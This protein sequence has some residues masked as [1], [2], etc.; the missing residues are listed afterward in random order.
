[1]RDEEFEGMRVVA[2]FHLLVTFPFGL[3][4]V[5]EN[6]VAVVVRRL[7][8][9]DPEI[10]AGDFSVGQLLVLFD[11]LCISPSSA[12]VEES[13]WGFHVAF[14]FEGSSGRGL[15]DAFSPGRA[16]AA[17]SGFVRASDFDP[18]TALFFVKE[19]A[20]VGALPGVGNG[21]DGLLASGWNCKKRRCEEKGEEKEKFH[22][23]KLKQI[24]DLESQKVFEL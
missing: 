12:Y 6:E 14:A 10:A 21:D 15:V 20:G 11:R 17:K 13:G 22:E 7:G 3:G 19:K 16:G 5:F 4:F 1:M 23:C 8:I 24:S 18:L 2:L 9:L